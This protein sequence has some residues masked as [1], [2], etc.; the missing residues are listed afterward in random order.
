MTFNRCLPLIL[1]L[2]PFELVHSASAGPDKTA[3]ADASA[4][5]VGKLIAELGLPD[6]KARQRATEQLVQFGAPALPALR[7]AATAT[8]VLEVKRRI[9][10]AVARIE[11]AIVNAEQKHWQDL[12]GPRPPWPVRGFRGSLVC[13]RL[14]RRLPVYR[15]VRRGRVT[16]VPPRASVTLCLAAQVARRDFWG[17]CLPCWGVSGNQFR[18]GGAPMRSTIRARI[19]AKRS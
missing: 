9:E 17:A 13:S 16:G 19:S 14:H 7:K 3:P 5:T 4:E 11:T 10:V 12:D 1:L 18:A 8:P 15:G 6:F 2:A